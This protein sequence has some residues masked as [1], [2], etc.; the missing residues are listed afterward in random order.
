MIEKEM[1]HFIIRQ[2]TPT[3]IFPTGTNVIWKNTFGQA[4]NHSAIETKIS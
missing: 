3:I 2:N 4:A 1:P